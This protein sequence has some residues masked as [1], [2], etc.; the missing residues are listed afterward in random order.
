MHK[1]LALSTACLATALCG[2]STVVVPNGTNGVEG[3]SSTGYPWNRAASVMHVQYCYDSTNFTL[4]GVNTPVVIN[5]LRW[6]ANSTTTAYTGGTYANVVIDLSTSAFDQAAQTTTFASNHGPDRTNVYTGTVTLLP[7]AG[8]PTTSPLTPN[9]FYVDVTLTTSFVYDPTSG[10]DLLMDI[11]FP[12]GSWTGGTAALPDCQ[13]TGSLSSRLYNLSSDT[14]ATGTRGTN[15][16]IVVEVGYAPAAGMYPAFSAT[17]TSGTSPLAVQ[18]TDQ[19]FT[20][21]PGGVLAWQ[22]DLDGD[23]IIDSTVQNPSFVYT[24]CGDYNVTLTTVDATHAPAT[25][26]MPA[27]ITVDP[28]TADFSAA[29]TSGAVPL[30]VQFTDASTNA[31]SWAWD[32][33]NDTV[34]DSTLQN[35]LWVY[36]L[37]GV[38]SVR[39]SVNNACRSDSVLKTNL[40]QV[41]GATSNTQ[42]PELLEFKFNEVRGETIANTASTT[43]MPA[44]ATVNTAGWQGDPGRPAFMGNEAGAGMLSNS[45][46]ASNTNLVNTGAPLTITGSMTLSWWDRQ[47]GTPPSTSYPFGGTGSAGVRIFTGGVAGT[48]LLYRGATL[49]GLTSGDVLATTNTQTHIGQWWHIALVIDD[50][51]G[52]ATWYFNGIPDPVVNYTPNTHVAAITEVHVGYH[53]STSSSYTAYYD[54]DDVRLYARALSQA[55]IVA[56]MAAESPT[57]SLFGDGCAGTIGVPTMSANSAPTLG[58]AGYAVTLGSAEDG[59][60]AAL[61]CGF[62]PRTVGP[63]DLS[64]F[65]GTG[66]ALQMDATAAF[67][68]VTAGNAAS[69]SLPI[70][71]LAAISGMHLYCQWLLLGTTGAVSPAIDISVH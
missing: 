51:A 47:A 22:W 21:D 11:A 41:V 39:L 28:L 29:P 36:T 59:R 27:F 35:P 42:S 61:V 68:S 58:N 66:C 32:F 49:T 10:G 48:S 50:A 38:Y 6:R 67:L 33:D 19:T 64:P 69:Q 53:T 3:N 4:Q 31:T 34:V 18:F 71:N 13:T 1:L 65:L 70:P 12:A 37:P 60:L 45:N 15:I 44:T 54:M 20:S 9:I 17:P 52:T 30:Q 40:I 8:V 55:E 23:S 14:A 62:Q 16:G 57:S 43:F 26:T 2:Q 7:S 56:M 5:R 24:A 46:A 25:V 63:I